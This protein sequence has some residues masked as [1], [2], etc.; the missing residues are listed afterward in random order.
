VGAEGVNSESWTQTR[1]IHHSN[2]TPKAGKF[3]E[4]TFAVYDVL[5]LI[6]QSDAKYILRIGV[7]YGRRGG[8][9]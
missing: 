5:Q 1:T 4:D 9:R 7:V 6:H 3:P 8:H 2:N